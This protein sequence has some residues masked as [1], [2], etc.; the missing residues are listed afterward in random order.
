M[1]D[2]RYSVEDKICMIGGLL[3]LCAGVSLLSIVELALWIVQTLISQAKD[4][5]RNKY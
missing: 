4:F 5:K 2:I 1:K 3:G